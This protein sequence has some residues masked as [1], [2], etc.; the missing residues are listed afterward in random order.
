MSGLPRAAR[1]LNYADAVVGSSVDE[2]TELVALLRERPGG[3]TW[4]QLAGAVLEHGTASVARAELTDASVVDAGERAAHLEEARRDVQA[5]LADGLEFWTIAD[6]RYPARVRDIQQAPPFLFA[7]GHRVD[8]DAAVSVVGSRKASER[9]LQLARSISEALVAMSVTVV[10]GLAAGI[11]T[12]AHETALRAGGRTVAVIGTGINRY[13]PV[14]NRALQ[15]RIA[16]DGLVLSQFWPDAPPQRHNFPM[17]NAIMSGYGIATVVV[18]AGEN[19]G[20]RI[21]ARMAVEHGRP[22]I[23]TDL[24]ISTTEWGK[25]LVGRP[26]V[27]LASSLQDLTGIVSEL[28]ARPRKLGAALGQITL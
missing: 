8:G 23:L 13:Y 10:A 7:R 26:D 14:A 20:A 1:R 19:S 18:E 11:D 9:G 22:V 3:L 2:Q 28:V 17:R 16:R 25:E 12:A 27:Y 24:V 15:A 21:Q 5:W 6:A 4:L